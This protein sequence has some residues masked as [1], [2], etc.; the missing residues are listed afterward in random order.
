M[1]G[2]VHFIEFETVEGGMMLVRSDAIDSMLETTTAPKG[3]EPQTR[4]H[5]VLRNNNR[6]EA[7]DETRETIK[8]KLMACSGSTAIIIHHRIAEPT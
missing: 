2:P 5:I 7:V 6:I 8:D 1:P 3:G 4:F